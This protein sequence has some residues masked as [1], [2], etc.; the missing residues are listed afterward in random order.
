MFIIKMINN[1]SQI[2][3][4][5]QLSVNTMN[6]LPIMINR[7]SSI[8]T[9]LSAIILQ[10]PSTTTRGC[11]LLLLNKISQLNHHSWIIALDNHLSSWPRLPT[12]DRFSL[13]SIISSINLSL[14]EPLP[15]GN[16]TWQ[17]KITIVYGKPWK[18]SYKSWMFIAMLWSTRVCL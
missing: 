1:V 7:H 16:L 18:T 17:R 4:Q 15:S 5:N 11:W 9:S 13:W 2:I 3:S 8:L 14:P 6:W 12:I 10:N